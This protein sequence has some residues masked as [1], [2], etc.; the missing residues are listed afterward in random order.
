MKNPSLLSSWCHRDRSKSTLVPE[1]MIVLV[2]AFLP[3]W[4]GIYHLPFDDEMFHILAAHSFSMDGT[5]RI[6][7]GEYA[8]TQIFTKLIGYLFQIFGE[9]LLVARLPALMAGTAWVL[10]VFLWVRWNISPIAAWTTTILF[11]FA[12]HGIELSQI[13]RFY[14]LHG[15]AFWLGAV[16]VYRLVTRGYESLKTILVLIATVF[17]FYFALTL[18]VTTYIGL[19][20]LV[21]WL[22]FEFSRHMV[23]SASIS[24]RTWL[25]VLGAVLVAGFSAVMFIPGEFLY[26]VIGS[27]TKV[28]YWNVGDDFLSYHRLFLAQ[29]PTLWSLFPLALFIAI[30]QRSREGIFCSCVFVVSLILHSGAGLKEERYIYYALPF[31]FI[32]WGIVFSELFQPLRNYWISIVNRISNNVF[33]LDRYSVSKNLLHVFMGG[34]VILFLL[35]SNGAFPRVIQLAL[36]NSYYFGPTPADWA[37]AGNYLKP[38]ADRVSVVV[39]TNITKSS[40]YLGRFH[41]AIN[42]NIVFEML[43]G[44]EFGLDPRTGLPAIST[45]D[46]LRLIRNCYSSGLFVGE[47][48][49]WKFPTRIDSPSADFLSANSER[50]KLPQEWNIIAFE[51]KSPERP[52]SQECSALLSAH[53]KANGET[54]LPNGK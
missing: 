22:V 25:T 13:A 9:S 43:N 24:L 30:A 10:A 37:S 5:L 40:Y 15:L 12:P 26:E 14:T 46:S 2:I 1:L 31:F 19:V 41:Y 6:A 11:S 17:C 34:I 47:L 8:R 7:F 21:A 33:S 20:G 49:E 3:R 39:T 52:K 45:I 48:S 28:S 27:Y 32:I 4:A 18:Q 51:W 16:G 50:I 38:Y 42:K 23:C 35:A 53:F 29:Y 44:E 54:L 36:G